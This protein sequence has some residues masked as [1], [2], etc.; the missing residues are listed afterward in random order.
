MIHF[1]FCIS[2]PIVPAPFVERL[3]PMNFIG[4]FL[5]NI[6]TAICVDLFLDSL[7]LFHKRRSALLKAKNI[8]ST[9]LVK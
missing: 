5:K 4:T 1:F 3:N 6:L 8:Q 2:Y 9:L 7:P